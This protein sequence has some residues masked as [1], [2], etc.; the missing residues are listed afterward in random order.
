MKQDDFFCSI[1]IT[2]YNWP[3]ALVKVLEALSKQSY[4]HFEVIVADD[5][6]HQDTSELINLSQAKY[7]FTLKHVWQHDDG[8]RAAKIRNKAAAIAQGS[9]LIFLDGDCVPQKTFVERHI[10]LAEQGWFIAGNR[11]LLSE[12]FSRDLLTSS[13]LN[14]IDAHCW[15][16]FLWR[17][18][19]SCN[20]ILPLLYMPFLLRKQRKNQWEGV[21]TCNL[22]LWKKDFLAVNGFDETYE[23]W[24]YEDSD[25]A[26]RL[27]RDGIKRKDGRYALCVIHLWHQEQDRS[28]EK[29]NL[30]RLAACSADIRNFAALGVNQY[31]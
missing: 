10:A 13:R 21:K 17:L 16:W 18:M 30:Q 24:G 22:G 11:L 26:I 31:L 29:Q 23:G 19:K 1:I 5:G 14:I 6:S 20:R 9:Y 4:K 27:L 3:E 7:S 2:T 28:L 25:L 15:N 12:K 8:F